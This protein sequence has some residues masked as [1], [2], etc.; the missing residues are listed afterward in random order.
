MVAQSPLMTKT[1]GPVTFDPWQVKIIINY[2]RKDIF[3]TFLGVS[4]KILVWDTAHV[5]VLQWS[6]GVMQSFL[7]KIECGPVLTSSVSTKYYSS[8]MKAGYVMLFVSLK[9][10]Y[11]VLLYAIS[12]CIVLESHCS[13]RP[14]G[15][16]TTGSALDGAVFD[17]AQILAY[18][19]RNMS[20]SQLYLGFG[21]FGWL[22]SFFSQ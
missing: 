7:S 16:T 15:K 5:P 22:P 11:M 17:I 4:E 13:T 12:C 18:L 6:P 3:W 20:R 19:V 10:Y 1:L 21:H 14:G 9:F 8:P 2:I